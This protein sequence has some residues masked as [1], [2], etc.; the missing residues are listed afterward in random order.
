MLLSFGGM[1]E[2][3]TGKLQQRHWGVL[4]QDACRGGD[5]QH[6]EWIF[7]GL[8]V[9]RTEAGSF[10]DDAGVIGS[11]DDGVEWK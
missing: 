9:C 8:G 1:K 3:W 2:L 5:T 11:G 10:S 7:V 6:L 4:V